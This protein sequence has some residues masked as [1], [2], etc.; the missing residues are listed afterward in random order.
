MLVPKGICF[1]AQLS[2]KPG[3]SAFTL[4]HVG[5]PA[6]R[7]FNDKMKFFYETPFG[8]NKRQFFIK[9]I[10]KNTVNSRCVA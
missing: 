2:A 3:S 4:N 8:E 5:A 1:T 9:E 10:L 7:P 6:G